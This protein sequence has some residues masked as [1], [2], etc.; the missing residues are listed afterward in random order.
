[1]LLTTGTILFLHENLLQNKTEITIIQDLILGMI[2][3]S[4]II[5]V[6]FAYE[7]KG[8]NASSGIIKLAVLPYKFDEIIAW[9]GYISTAGFILALVLAPSHILLVS[10]F[11]FSI[12]GLVLSSIFDKY[13]GSVVRERR[14]TLDDGQE[15]SSYQLTQLNYCFLYTI[16]GLSFLI[17]GIVLGIVRFSA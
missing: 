1:M 9:S 10:G 14:E 15:H 7:S 6:Y 13:P 12:V 3:L 11:E 8:D 16:V 5:A 2:I 4:L 17:A